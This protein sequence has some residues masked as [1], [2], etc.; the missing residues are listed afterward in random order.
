MDSG[1]P[2]GTPST[3]ATSP[4]PCDSPAV[5]NLKCMA[6]L[7]DVLM[8]R[9]RP[10]PGS[11]LRAH[12]Y[13]WARTR[14]KGRRRSVAPNVLLPHVH[15]DHTSR[16]RDP[17]QLDQHAPGRTRT[18]EP[19][20]VF[21]ERERRLQR[22]DDVVS[23]LDLAH[24]PEVD[25]VDDPDGP[26][27]GPNEGEGRRVGVVQ[28][29]AMTRMQGRTRSASVFELTLQAQIGSEEVGRLPSAGHTQRPVQIETETE[30]PLGR[31]ADQVHD[32]EVAGDRLGRG[33]P[34]DDPARRCAR[35]LAERDPTAIARCS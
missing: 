18:G 17:V 34:H 29:L 8:E 13:R 11:S 33:V 12:L 24:L 9:A 14:C 31:V 10:R 32:R 4:R 20:V 3:T 25:G 16:V 30:D 7:D 6:P 5:P 27:T 15:H 26:S 2:A 22:T 35:S 21:G 1:S 28:Y 23:D 19:R